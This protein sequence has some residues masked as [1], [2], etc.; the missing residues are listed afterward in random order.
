MKKVEKVIRIESL[1]VVP[2]ASVTVKI[3][4]GRLGLLAMKPEE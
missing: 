1:A 3:K 2:F 4:D